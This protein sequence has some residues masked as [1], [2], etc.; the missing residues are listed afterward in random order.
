MNAKKGSRRLSINVA[1][2]WLPPTLQRGERYR[3]RVVSL[4]GTV[5]EQ[6]VP[7]KARNCRQTA[8]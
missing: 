3:A 7:N 8:R 4:D 6:N 2:L 1:G 5:K